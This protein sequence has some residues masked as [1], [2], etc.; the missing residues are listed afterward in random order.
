MG[1]HVCN[2]VC[3]YIPKRLIFNEILSLHILFASV[4]DMFVFSFILPIMQHCCLSVY[5]R[6]N[7]CALLL[8]G[9][10]RCSSL[11]NVCCVILLWLLYFP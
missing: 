6:T 4:H 2:I 1:W 9:T 11:C 5:L 7:V 3:I 10:L 8:Y